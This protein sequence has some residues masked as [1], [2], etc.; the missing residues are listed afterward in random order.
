MTF[1]SI[2]VEWNAS[3]WMFEWTKKVIEIVEDIQPSLQKLGVKDIED[4]VEGYKTIKE[5]M[6]IIFTKILK[7]QQF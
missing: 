7:N 4:K 3:A 1:I 2:Q 6:D 5:K